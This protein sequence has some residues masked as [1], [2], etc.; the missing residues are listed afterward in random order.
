MK[1]MKK[2]TVHIA[3]QQ[4]VRLKGLADA[5]G[6]KQAELLRR[7]LEEGLAPMERELRQRVQDSGGEQTTETRR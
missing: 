7:C 1:T 4:Y 5:L 2:I 6:M 3:D